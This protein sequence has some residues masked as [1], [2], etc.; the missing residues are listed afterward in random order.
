[1]F[2]L[3]FEMS[4]EL[5]DNSSGEE[6]ALHETHFLFWSIVVQIS[7]EYFRQQDKNIFFGRNLVVAEVAHDEV[8]HLVPQSLAA[9][10]K[11]SDRHHDLLHVSQDVDIVT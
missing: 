9:E 5:S 1:M 2:G 3:F 10:V 4:L 7:V 8:I 6:L 11:D